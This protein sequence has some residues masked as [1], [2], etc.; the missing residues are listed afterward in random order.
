MSRAQRASRRRGVLNSPVFAVLV[1]VGAAW[2]N[3]STLRSWIDGGDKAIV[4]RPDDRPGS[5]MAEGA[6]PVAPDGLARPAAPGGATVA[7]RPFLAEVE[8]PDPFHHEVVTDSVAPE[9]AAAKIAEIAARVHVS[10]VFHSATSRLAVID[11]HV[12]EVGDE[13]EV[14]VVQ[15]IER[16]GVRIKT[17]EGVVFV[18]LAAKAVAQSETSQEAS[19][20][21]A[22]Q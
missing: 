14:G 6:G 10:V 22:D 19:S 12:V 2:V 3:W 17:P 13:V 8:L 16:D 1:V 9:Q 18:P 7:F 4:V 11:G 15:A 21:P 5:T 20:E